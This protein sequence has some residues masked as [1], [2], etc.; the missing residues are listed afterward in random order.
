MLRAATWLLMLQCGTCFLLTVQHQ[1]GAP[2]R[3]PSRHT[4]A[5][6]SVAS[7]HESLSMKAPD[8][9]KDGLAQPWATIVTVGYYGI[10][11]CV[12]GKMLLVVAERIL[13]ANS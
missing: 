9:G 5:P 3:I 8:D 12:F 11:V 6:S 7:I 2:L 4:F 13:A 10:Y 1:H